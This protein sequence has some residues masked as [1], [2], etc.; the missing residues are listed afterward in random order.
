M[1]LLA[2]GKWAGSANHADI[3]GVTN[4]LRAL[5]ND[6]ASKLDSTNVRLA[7]ADH[8]LASFEQRE[9]A[10]SAE[11]V[12]TLTLL[13]SVPEIASGLQNIADLSATGRLGIV[14]DRAVRVRLLALEN[15]LAVLQTQ[16]ETTV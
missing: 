4:E 2:A 8:F 15:E 5:R 10:S 12:A 3:D 1:L 9:D 16:D 7:S 13:S 11:L 14:H 6:A